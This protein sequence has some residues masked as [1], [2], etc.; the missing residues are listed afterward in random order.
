M[1]QSKNATP[2]LYCKNRVDHCNVHSGFIPE[3]TLFEPL[4]N[5]SDLCVMAKGL[6]S[7]LEEPAWV[8]V[9][10][11]LH[12]DPKCCEYFDS[13]NTGDK[14]HDH[15]EAPETA[16]TKMMLITTWNVQKGGSS[17]NCQTTAWSP[18]NLVESGIS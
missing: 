3:Q 1:T 5:A 15:G 11:H 7:S 14:D 12:S 18:K 4:V 17:K 16:C 10:L 2:V 13:G 6:C 9:W 8:S